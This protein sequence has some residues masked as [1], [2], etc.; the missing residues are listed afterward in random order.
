[1]YVC[2]CV[3]VSDEWCWC[4]DTHNVSSFLPLPSSPSCDLSPFARK[5]TRRTAKTTTKTQDDHLLVGDKVVKTIK[6]E[7]GNAKAGQLPYSLFCLR[8]CLYTLTHSRTHGQHRPT[9]G[10]DEVI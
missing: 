6:D 1:M 9:T 4:G 2:V 7:Q 10:S 5:E 8:V 3:G